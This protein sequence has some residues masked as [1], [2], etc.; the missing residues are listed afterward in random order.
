MSFIGHPLLGLPV[1]TVLALFLHKKSF[2]S[3]Q[4]DDDDHVYRKICKSNIYS[5][6]Y[7]ILKM[8]QNGWFSYLCSL[9]DKKNM[10]HHRPGYG[11]IIY[12]KQFSSIGLI[13]MFLW[14]QTPLKVTPL[15]QSPLRIFNPFD[16]GVWLSVLCWGDNNGI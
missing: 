5:N 9:R 11:L 13:G 15:M 14:F 7:G 1:C 2:A 12:V 4:V 16:V 8:F 3:H 10:S 6:W